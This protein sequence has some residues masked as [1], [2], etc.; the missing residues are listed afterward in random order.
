MC[1]ET[2]VEDSVYISMKYDTL[3][4]ALERIL[5]NTTLI[6]HNTDT[7]SNIW[8]TSISIISLIAS[9]VTVIGFLSIYYELHK[10]KTSKQCRKVLIYDLIRHFF[11]VSAIVEALKI[12]MKDEYGKKVPAESIFG[13]MPALNEDILFGNYYV[14]ADHF[15]LIH[16]IGFGIRNF[17][18]V[19]AATYRLLKDPNTATQ[20]QDKE[21]DALLTRAERICNELTILCILQN[22]IF[23]KN[24]KKAKNKETEYNKIASFIR[25]SYNERIQSWEMKGLLEVDDNIQ[26][27]ISQKF[28]SEHLKVAD[29]MKAC[30]KF[31][32]NDISIIN[33]HNNE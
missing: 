12:L 1:E 8:S 2:F 27:N 7:W 17:N 31:R 13:R 26:I 32:L 5:K 33:L 6:E 28:F 4:E 16:R 9:I 30:I 3:E 22:N 10:R 18:S 19:S 21:F 15:D 20:I 11:I 24:P 29:T 25:K 23:H 14:D